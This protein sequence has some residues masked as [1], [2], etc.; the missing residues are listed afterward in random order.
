L[1][2]GLPEGV[3]VKSLSDALAADP[4][5]VL[6]HLGRYAAF[7][8]QAFVALN[9]AL[10]ADGIVIRVPENTSVESPIHILHI[11]ADQ[12]VASQSHPRTLIMGGKNARLTVVE[13]YLGLNG[14]AHFTNAVTE[15]AA[16]AD[17]Q[18]EYV[19]MVREPESS[20]HIATV[21][22]H[23]EADSRV[24]AH[25][26]TI[27]G[28][29]VRTATNAALAGEGAEVN[30][31]GLYLLRGRQHVDNHTRID[32]LVPHGT[33]SE[34]FKGILDGQSRA[35]FNGRIVVHSDAQKTDARQSN[36]NLMLSDKALV[37]T[38]PQLEIYADDVK[39]AHGSTVGQIDEEALFYFRSR[40]IDIETARRLL[41]HGFT[42]E[43]IDLIGDESVRSILGALVTA[44]LPEGP[45][46]R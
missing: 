12:G 38:N 40:G 9:T 15:L 20:H 37:N 27:G 46:D 16:R 1:L 42:Q 45:V 32:H 18:I 8:Q 5:E 36:K 4:A 2:D 24:S 6:P 39:C 17:S 25:V 44:W 10:L 11:A 21:Q 7:E 23:Q 33:S 3:L 30:L 14:N 19:R 13:H 35:V 26:A 22:V 43:I 29:L 31:N 28:G 34:N 41:I